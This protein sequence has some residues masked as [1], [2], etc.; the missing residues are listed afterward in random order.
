MRNRVLVTVVLAAVV[1]MV[2]AACGP[3]ATATPTR[4]AATPTPTGPIGE[5][6]VTM[7]SFSAE[8]WDP[9]TAPVG[10]NSHNMMPP[11]FDFLVGTKPDASLAPGIAERWEM[12]PDG[13]IWTFYLRRNA[14]FHN[15]DP[16]TA[17]DVKF[18][19]ERMVDKKATVSFAGTLR[20]E[21]KTAEVV[22][23][24]TVRVTLNT[25][26]PY[27]ALLLS[28]LQAGLG[29]IMPKDYI[30]K[31]GLDNFLQKPMGSGNFK[32]VRHV[33]GDRVEYEALD[34]HWRKVPAFRRLTEMVVPDPGTQVAMLR[35]GQ[36]DIVE[37][38][39]DRAAEVQAAGLKVVRVP[40]VMQVVLRGFSLDVPEAG[41]LYN[42]KVREALSLAIN[43]DEIIQFIM[44]GAGRPAM[45]FWGGTTNSFDIVR[46][47]WQAPEYNLEKA[48]RLLSEAGYAQGF[49]VK[50]YSFPLS[51]A[52]YL[53]KM[54]DAIQ[55]MWR[56][57]GVNAELVPIDF[58]A[59]LPRIIAK[60]PA[61]E[62]V[63]TFG[64]WRSP[65]K[66]NPP[67]GF[68][69]AYGKTAQI[70]TFVNPELQKLIAD[71]AKEFDA[72]KRQQMV[73]DASGIIRD[74]FTTYPIADGDGVYGMGKN[75]GG[76][77]P[78]NGHPFI[79]ILLETVT[80]A[81]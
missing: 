2:L 53:P 23:D 55:G 30:E 8:Q 21:M 50:I 66:Y 61:K 15:G 36:A 41:P 31:Q 13:L 18:S 19:L 25:P 44:G 70:R 7:G 22:D 40:A 64:V 43:R 78:V 75:I 16:V 80:H 29:T 4:P 32:F 42:V 60:P 59:L 47:E 79:G 54:A 33:K 58:G 5:L 38:P 63:G 45:P 73:R 9:T 65:T 72:T 77:T 20:S 1:T 49:N 56:Q 11:I 26:D 57:V 74:T 27:L 76:W 35:S 28:P 14:K 71:M 67:V 46:S 39:A 10:E 62:V 12:A 6:R 68:E 17:K 69:S 52:P 34:Q 3:A 37:L 24:Y 81:K 48:K 51:Q